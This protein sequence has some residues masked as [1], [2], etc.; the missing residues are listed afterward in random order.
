MWTYLKV[1]LWGNFNLLLGCQQ[2]NS[3]VSGY[4]TLISGSGLIQKKQSGFH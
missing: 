2:S 4:Q 3:V 1:N